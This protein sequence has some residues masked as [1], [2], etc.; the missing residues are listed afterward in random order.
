M[1]ERRREI[2]LG[3]QIADRLLAWE[4]QDENPYDVADAIVFGL[5]CYARESA[6]PGEMWFRCCR[7]ALLDRIVWGFAALPGTHSTLAAEEL[8]IRLGSVTGGSWSDAR[9]MGSPA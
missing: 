4:E 2:E 5:Q 9:T 3:W 8:H 1:A 7:L 6:W